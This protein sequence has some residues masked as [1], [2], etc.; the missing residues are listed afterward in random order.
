MK[1]LVTGAAGFLGGHLIDMLL[2]RGDD[3]RALVQPGQDTTHLQKLSG[4]EIY[5][6][7]LTN[8]TS[9]KR[10]VQGIQ[11]VYN[12][13]AK[14]GPWGPETLYQHV[15]VRG[16]S[17]L[18]LAAMEAGVQRIIHT[19]SITI[20]GH[21]LQG[22]ITEDAPYYTEDNPYSRSKIAGEQLLARLVQNHH[23][24]V[25]I[26]RPGW[27]YG[28][29]DYASF[30]RFV[31]LVAS[32]KGFLLGDGKNIVP[33]VYVRDVAQSLI[34]AGDAGL[35]TIGRAYTIVNDQRVTQSE[36]LNT[37]AEMIQKPHISRSIPF[38]PVH[39]I[40]RCTE[41]LWRILDPRRKVSPP[42][43]SYGVALLGRS[44]QFSID[45]A[46]H[47]L[48]F[49]PVFDIQHGIAEGVEWYLKQSISN[50]SSP[51]HAGV[52]CFSGKNS[53]KA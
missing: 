17:D 8:T 43:S 26:V 22:I 23:A 19:S 34:K 38:A 1:S 27:I 18:V 4:V 3:I 11:R 29:R 31:R 53:I 20:Y 24:P 25:V 44:Q 45:R 5:Q 51:D 12:V 9:L 13:A 30:S 41:M 50:T 37:I 14:T 40:A 33:M 16:L 15:N 32:G 42:L 35:K 49:F 39:S 6:G 47:E 10:A 21:N 7:D 2:E 48:G 36:Y 28:P 52:S 46:R